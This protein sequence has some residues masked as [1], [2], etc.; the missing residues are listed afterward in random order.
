MWY[1]VYCLDLMLIIPLN[2][3]VYHIWNYY[4]VGSTKELEKYSNIQKL[5]SKSAK[6]SLTSLKE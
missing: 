3:K 6:K 1:F 2:L 5:F 4:I